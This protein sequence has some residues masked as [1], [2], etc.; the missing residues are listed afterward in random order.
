M[1]KEDRAQVS[2]EYMLILAVSL[3]ILVVFTMPL[4]NEV[5]SNTFDVSDS[6]N[7]KSDISAIAQSIKK[8]YGEGEGSRQTITID[9]KKPVKIDISNNQ[10]SSKIKLNNNKYKVIKINVKSKLKTT[11]LKLDEGKNSMVVE[12]PVGEENMILYAI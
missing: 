6:L 3:I 7:T 8:V 11:A 1:I 5:M 9:V 4:L 12:W 10:I 2:L